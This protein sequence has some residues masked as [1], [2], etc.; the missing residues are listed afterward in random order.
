VKISRG[1]RGGVPSEGAGKVHPSDKERKLHPARS[2]KSPRPST[3]DATGEART[4]TAL[5]RAAWGEVEKIVRTISGGGP[6]TKKELPHDPA[7]NAK[8]PKDQV[9]GGMGLKGGG[10]LFGIKA[11]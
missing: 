3:E 6:L 7:E 11:L 4:K 8:K 2:K 1:G 5:L 9:P 10:E